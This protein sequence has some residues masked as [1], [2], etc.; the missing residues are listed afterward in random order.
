MARPYVPPTPS[1]VKLRALVRRRDDLQEMLQMEH[2]RLDVAD[3]S[4]QQGIKDVIRTLEEQI[5]QVQ[6]AIEDHIDNDPDL[7]RRHQ[8][9]TSI[10]GVGNTSSAQLLAML[11]DLSKYSD[12]RQVVAH[13]GLNPAQRQ[14]GN[15]EG[16]C[17]ISRV[18]DANFRKKLYMP[19]LTGK[20][21]NPTLKSFA[22]RLSAKGK[23]FKVVM[24]AVM[25]KLIHL[26]WGVLRS[27]RPFEPDVALA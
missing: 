16:K 9:L 17:R 2:N 22:D 26:I 21:H 25:R 1:E 6:K 23:P 3:I 11:G 15:Y 4:V 19:A 8:L 18:G 14:S 7:R 24:C 5:K 12:V 27:G 10:P 13:A 20:T